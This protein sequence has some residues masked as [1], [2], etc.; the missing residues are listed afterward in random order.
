MLGGS[1]WA[2]YEKSSTVVGNT[3]AIDRVFNDKHGLAGKRDIQPEENMKAGFFG[4][5]LTDANIMHT[6]IEFLTYLRLKAGLW[7]GAPHRPP[8]PPKRRAPGALYCQCTHHASMATTNLQLQRS[9][10]ESLWQPGEKTPK[11]GL[12]PDPA[13]LEEPGSGPNC[14]EGPGSS[15]C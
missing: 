11:R 6:I 7:D 12:D 2:T 14:P 8:P 15:S 3:D 4:R 13:A 1:F 10:K 5:P 9:Q